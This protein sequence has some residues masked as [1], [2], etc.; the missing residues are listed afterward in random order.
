[1]ATKKW[2]HKPN[3]WLYHHGQ[4]VMAFWV[5]SKSQAKDIANN[6]IS[7]RKKLNKLNKVKIYK[8]DFNLTQTEKGENDA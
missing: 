3:F 2:R 7:V 6:Y 5:Q 1:M 8:K 4:I